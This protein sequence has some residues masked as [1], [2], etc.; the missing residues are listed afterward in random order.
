MYDKIEKFSDIQSIFL[1]K[2][3]YEI[4]W[5]ISQVVIRIHWISL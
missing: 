4:N 2:I 1:I 3:V 5:K